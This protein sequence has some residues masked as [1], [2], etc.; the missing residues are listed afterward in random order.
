MEKKRLYSCF[1]A[2]TDGAGITE[3]DMKYYN[4]L[5]A[6]KNNSRVEFDFTNVHDL[7]PIPQAILDRDDEPKI[8]EYL[9]KRL[10]ISEEFILIVGE[11][12]ANLYKYVRWEIERAVVRNIPIIVVNINGK[13]EIDQKYCPAILRD[14]LAVHISFDYERI[15]H[16]VENWPREHEIHKGR[17]EIYPMFWKR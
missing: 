16:S 1:D 2:D 3:S 8:K 9:E 17:N 7:I 5:K 11:H 14:K 4:L 12:T 13:E 15:K 10:A 6:W